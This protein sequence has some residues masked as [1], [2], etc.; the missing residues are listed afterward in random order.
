MASCVEAIAIAR[1]VG[2]RA[3]EGH[4]RNTLGF[5]QTYLGNPGEGVANLRESLL[6]AEEVGDV[7]DLC[8]AYLNLSDCLAGPLNR[9]EEG[10]QLALEGA[11]LSQRRG[12][13]SDYGVSIQS[14]AAMA[15]I[16]L[17]R[18][19]RG[20]RGPAQRRVAEPERD[21]RRRSPAD[22]GA[23]RGLL[24][25]VRRGRGPHRD[26]APDDRRAGPAVPTRRSARWRREDR[27]LAGP[28]RR[29]PDDGRRRA[30]AGRQSMAGRAAR[31][32]RAVGAR[33]RGGRPA[34]RW[35]GRGTGRRRCDGQGRRVGTGSSLPCRAAACHGRDARLCDAVRGRGGRAPH[36]PEQ[37]SGGAT[38]P[39]RGPPSAS[40]ISRCT[41][42][43]GKRRRCWLAA[44]PATGRPSFGARTRP[45]AV[46]APTIS[47]ASSRC[48]RSVP[49]SSW[50]R[51]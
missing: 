5:V 20:P 27:S 30:R 42:S 47:G 39:L 23:P 51:P 46:S 26:G 13:A 10:L 50:R 16:R 41:R 6:I 22:P 17:G 48:S 14:N 43:C 1:R 40:H 12:T 49:G 11:A 3:E 32:A 33:R 9:L 24:G 35:H 45:R 37:R 25:S 7:D 38:S 4:A 44:I 29:R 2:A 8:R 18:L 34:A 19:L 21:R 15:L 28:A 36:R 31:V